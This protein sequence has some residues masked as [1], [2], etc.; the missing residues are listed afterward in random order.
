MFREL[1]TGMSGTGKSTALEE[2]RRRGYETLDTDEDGW[3]EWS[4]DDGYVWDEPRMAEILAR[5]HQA[6]LYVSGT[7]SNQVGSTLGSMQSCC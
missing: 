4:D 5:D 3:S 6:T 7:V 1:I 2:L